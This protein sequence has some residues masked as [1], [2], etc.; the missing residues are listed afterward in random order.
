MKKHYHYLSIL[1][2][3]GGMA[4]F[5]HACKDDDEPEPDPI[6]ITYGPLAVKVNNYDGTP[7]DNIEVTIVEN[8]GIVYPDDREVPPVSQQDVI[9]STVTTNADGLA[10][11]DSVQ[12]ETPYYIRAAKKGIGFADDT[13]GVYAAP[14]LVDPNREDFDPAQPFSE[15]VDSLKTVELQLDNQRGMEVRFNRPDTLRTAFDSVRLTMFFNQA[16]FTANKV[17]EALRDTVAHIDSTVEFLPLPALGTVASGERY[18]FRV[19]AIDPNG[20]PNSDISKIGGFEQVGRFLTLEE[21]SLNEQNRLQNV[22]PISLQY[23]GSVTVQAVIVKVD[24]STEPANAT[25]INF[26]LNPIDIELGREDAP[27]TVLTAPESN[28]DASTSQGK[29]PFIAPNAYFLQATTTDEDGIIYRNNPSDPESVRVVG[30]K[31]KNV[32]VELRP[33]W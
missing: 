16:D 27:Y 7:A 13:A 30:G 10:V 9:K 15:L 11:L 6:D 17:G 5:L 31:N 25:N 21:R 19:Q 4:L 18:F 20:N 32:L 3:A 22:G 2:L 23:S 33:R 14:N 12:A 1:A 29:A 24:G 8:R 28:D 26:F